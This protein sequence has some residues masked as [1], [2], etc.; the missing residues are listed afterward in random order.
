MMVSLVKGL[1]ARLFKLWFIL[2][3]ISIY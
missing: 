2:C 1:A 3:H